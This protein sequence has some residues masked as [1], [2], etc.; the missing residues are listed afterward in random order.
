MTHAVPL[1]Q[2]APTVARLVADFLSAPP[3]SAAAGM[4]ET[5]VWTLVMLELWC[6]MFVDDG[7]PRSGAVG[8]KELVQTR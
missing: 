8:T 6:R 5:R 7:A 4:A 3:A 1:P 2:I